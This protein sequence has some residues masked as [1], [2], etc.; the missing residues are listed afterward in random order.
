MK[1]S[2]IIRKYR[3]EKKIG[4]NAFADACDVGHTTIQSIEE[5][6]ASPS[7]T[8]LKKIAKVLKIGVAELL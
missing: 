8:T 4:R 5:N 1:A 3:L 7:L 2:K 6:T